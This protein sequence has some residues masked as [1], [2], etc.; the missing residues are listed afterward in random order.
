[1]EQ[2]TITAEQFR[3]GKFK[4]VSKQKRKAQKQATLEKLAGMTQ[5][6]EKGIKMIRYEI[7][8]GKEL[9][10]SGAVHPVSEIGLFLMVCKWLVI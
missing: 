2:K 6:T 10:Q 4:P 7:R 8:E 5:T 1:M 9:I 3:T